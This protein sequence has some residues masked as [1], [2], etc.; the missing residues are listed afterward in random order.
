MQSLTL[1]NPLKD[2]SFSAFS[3][4]SFTSETAFRIF[5]VL[6]WQGRVY[7]PLTTAVHQQVQAK[8]LYCTPRF[9]ASAAF[10][11]SCEDPEVAL[12]QKTTN[13]YH[14]QD[15]ILLPLSVDFCRYARARPR[16][17]EMLLTMVTDGMVAEPL[18]V[19]LTTK[20]H[21]LARTERCLSAH[22]FTCATRKTER[23]WW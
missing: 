5:A 12:P 16:R 14:T 21:S 10:A 8:E 19:R 7:E 2:R 15:C 20:I 22:C 1:H 23:L 9:R 3:V 18:M 13:A 6:T 17:W 4:K 11:S